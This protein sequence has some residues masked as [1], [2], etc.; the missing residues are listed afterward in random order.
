M[1]YRS[2]FTFLRGADRCLQ[3]AVRLLLASL[4]AIAVPRLGAEN[5]QTLELRLSP[6]RA[7]H[8]FSL[9]APSGTENSP[10]AS[11]EG[12]FEL[13]SPDGSFIRLQVWVDTEQ[14][15]T[16]MDNTAGDHLQ[17]TASFSMSFIDPGDNWLLPD[18][19]GPSNRHYFLIGPDRVGH[20][21]LV[22]DGGLYMLPV[23]GPSVAVNGS[24]PVQHRFELAVTGWLS[25]NFWMI[26]LT[27]SE[28]T[29][30]GDVH[31][32]DS[33]WVTNTAPPP[34]GQAI[35]FLD[36]NQVGQTFT[37]HSRAAGGTEHLQSVTANWLDCITGSWVIGSMDENFLYIPEDGGDGWIIP[38]GSGV[39]F[40]TVGYGMEFW[41]T[42]NTDGATGPVR[43][44]G[45]ATIAK[46]WFPEAFSPPPPPPPIRVD[47]QF[48]NS[49]TGYSVVYYDPVNQWV[50]SAAF[51]AIGG[52][53]LFSYDDYGQIIDSLYYVDAYAEIPANSLN[54]YIWDWTTGDYYN[55]LNWNPTHSEPPS[56]SPSQL[57][58]T[59]FSGRNDHLLS[60]QQPDSAG[61]YVT[62]CSFIAAT[63]DFY[64][65][66]SYYNDGPGGWPW[67]P[68]VNDYGATIS[69]QVGGYQETPLYT[70]LNGVQTYLHNVFTIMAAYDANKPFRIVDETAGEISSENTT[71]LGLWYPPPINKQ[72]PITSSRW[73]HDL[74]LLQPGGF[75]A[76]LT[77]HS[78]AGFFTNA[79]G[80]AWWVNYYYF[81][82]SVLWHDFLPWQIEDRSASPVERT[83]FYPDEHELVSEWIHLPTPTDLTAQ[84]QSGGA[85]LAWQG[86]GT[87]ADG[88]FAVE[89]RDITSAIWIALPGVVPASSS[90]GGSMVF[91][92]VDTTALPSHGYSYRIRYTFGNMLSPPSLP[93]SVAIGIDTDGDGIADS[94]DDDDDGDGMSDSE[95]V[96]AGTDPKR[97]DNPLLFLSAF[98]ITQP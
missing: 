12:L 71:A 10:W 25:S 90:S 88:G 77:Q 24:N 8:G 20:T 50:S 40:A 66:G 48:R 21:F 67:L 64:L 11:F 43:S 92:S 52:G 32:A 29:Q 97:K 79:G 54:W 57:S 46:W 26:D 68:F 4:L 28:R 96:A 78:T 47:A 22:R 6:G 7:A 42:R 2:H 41:L 1:N 27:T 63:G 98:G 95:E 69:V 61:N 58:L 14:P 60:V 3:F 39:I 86:K 89:R 87:S 51:T 74:W 93:A 17:V 84:A 31:L 72:L 62:V 23:L 15:F 19:S 37:L 59:I 13:P 53:T 65:D 76:P 45:V 38:E 30:A 9:V 36:A 33:P 49:E 80:V 70:A 34:V 73:T 83:S 85:A 16:L 94:S 56:V 75:S 82:A 91:T 81:D 35:I 18:E 5:W 55:G 44:M